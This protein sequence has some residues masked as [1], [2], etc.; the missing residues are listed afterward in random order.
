MKL[1]VVRHGQT[2]WNLHNQLQGWADTPIN[3]TGRKQAEELHKKIRSLDFDVCY[4]STLK[5]AA[6]TA[7]I[8]VGYQSP[9]E[10]PLCL[11]RYDKRLRE[12]G[13]GKIDSLNDEKTYD[14][15]RNEA[16][17]FDL[18]TGKFGI[19]PIRSFYARVYDFFHNEIAGLKEE[20]GEDAKILIVTHGGTSRV[21]NY[22]ILGGDL[23]PDEKSEIFQKARKFSLHN[24]EMVE[25][26]I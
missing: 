5:R 7:Q 24:C 14:F 18:N 2:D 6:I 10:K 4:C 20:F 15:I 21:L 12:R 26:N 19:E 8:V 25:Y 13:F 9:E 17:D 1:F 3:E 23:I 16:W 22:V 11:I